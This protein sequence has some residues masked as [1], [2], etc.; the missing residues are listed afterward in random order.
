ML[1]KSRSSN[2]LQRERKTF[3]IKMIS[4]IAEEKMK[5]RFD[6]ARKLLKA[7]LRMCGTLDL[8]SAANM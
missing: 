6:N 2:R 5:P 1:R 7:F 8:K 4:A 3:P